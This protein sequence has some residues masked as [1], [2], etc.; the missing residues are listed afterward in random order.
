M[1]RLSEVH[2]KQDK[3]SIYWVMSIFDPLSKALRSVAPTKV[4]P[5]CQVMRIPGP[6]SGMQYVGPGKFQDVPPPLSESFQEVEMLSLTDL[7]SLDWSHQYRE[8][9]S[10]SFCVSVCLIII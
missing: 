8:M 9:S 4:S 2:L 7:W 1:A 6:G 5:V 3:P 10:Q